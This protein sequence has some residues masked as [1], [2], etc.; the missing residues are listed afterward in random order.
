MNG[1]APS[2]SAPMVVSAGVSALTSSEPETSASCA[3]PLIRSVM[4]GLNLWQL[5]ETCVQTLWGISSLV[6]A[7]CLR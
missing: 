1:F 7:E 3:T 5:I 2:D 6:V 4:V